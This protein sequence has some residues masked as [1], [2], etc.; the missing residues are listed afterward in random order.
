MTDT[1][2]LKVC[3]VSPMPSDPPWELFDEIPDDIPIIVPDDS[4]GNL[5]PAPRDNVTYFD[6]A[7]Q[8]DYCG[9]HYDAMPHKSAASRNF[10]HYWAY[11][12]GFD[13]IIALDFDC[14]TRPGWLSDHLAT[15]TTVTDHPAVQGE[16]I[17]S[18]EC[19]GFYARGY[20][21]EYRTPERSQVTDTTA[22]GRVVI[23]M[24]VWDNILD[25]NG[26]D[27]YHTEPPY[28]PGLRGEQNYVALGNIPVCGMNNSFLAEITPAYYFLPDLWVERR[29]AG[30]LAAQSPRR[31]LGWLHP[32]EADGHQGRPLHLRP[33]D[34]RAHQADAARAGHRA[35]AVHAPDVDG[36]LQHRRR[37]GGQRDRR[38]LS[39]RSS[40][41]SSRSTIVLSS[42]VPSRPTTSGSTASSATGWAVGSERSPERREVCTDGR[43]QRRRAQGA[44]GQGEAGAGAGGPGA[45]ARRD[46]ADQLHQ[47]GSHRSA[48]ADELGDHAQRR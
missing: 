26:I 3:V 10:G 23:N 35:R 47:G 11:K 38:R 40:P 36:V 27:K 37:R 46:R 29:I 24:G 22:S 17:N 32:Q 45:R 15:L 25:L 4:D 16:W 14:G 18:V 44:D 12:E 2:D 13:V 41:T 9:E 34:R 6:Y 48:E 19:E 42:A 39:R 7:A 43:R 30:Q 20:P 28:D 31:H 5:A 1:N 21:Y 33:P 8:K